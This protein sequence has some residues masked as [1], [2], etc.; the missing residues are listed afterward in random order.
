M[1]AQM[2]SRQRMLAAI[3]RQKPDRVPFSP[4][5]AQGP[6]LQEP[7]FWRD[8]MERAHRMLE[9][10]MDPTID[11][12]LPDPQPHP[13]VEIKAW[14][15]N[16]GKETL[17]TKE[18]HTPAGVL[19]QVVRETE[20]WCICR[21]VPWVPTTWGIEKRDSCGVDLFDDWNIPRRLE[22]WVKGREDLDKLRYVIR[23]AEGYVLDE[24]RM[25]AQRA[26]ELARRL[27]VLTMA[28]R[29]I[30]GDAFQWFCDIPWFM[31]QLYDDP[32]FVTDF[33]EIFQDWALGLVEL[34]LEA[35]VD[36]VQ[37]RGWYETPT[38]WGERFWKEHIVPII[39][40]Q[41]ERVHSAGKLFS[42]LLPEGQGAYADALK[43]IDIDVLQGVDPR[44]LHVGDARSMFETLGDNK[45]FWGG[46]NGEVTLQSQDPDVI[47]REVRQAIDILG[48][49][50]GLIL[51]AFLYRE[52]PPQGTLYMIDAWR[53]YR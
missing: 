4:Y 13:D 2:S 26:M 20:D 5:V 7:L 49:N 46:V 22:P 10:E 6:W 9:L 39:R 50:G 43:D 51:S 34:A 25:D 40:P 17:I 36:V 30:V 29:T 47:E 48:A 41:A 18:Y 21:H 12:W 44:M 45:A 53:K 11:I 15:E 31:T 1:P 8:Q 52:V 35:E 28:R 27:D 14:R 23:P 32:P 33:L 37:Y 38:F 42:Y 19:R 24:W 3:T 16:K